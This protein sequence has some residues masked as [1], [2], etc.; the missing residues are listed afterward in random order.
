M[1][2][3]MIMQLS[4]I[5]KFAI[6]A[7][8]ILFAV[9]IHEVAHGWMASKLGD[10]T[11][12]MLGRL[13]LNPIRHIDPVGTIII[14][15]LLLWIGGFIFGWAKPVPINPKNLKNPRRDLALISISGPLSNL[16]MAVIWAM[17]MK[18]GV[19]LTQAGIG[20]AYPII[21]MGNAGITINL[22]LGLLNLIPIPPLDGGHFVSSILPRRLAHYY[23]RL[24]RY[25]FIII[26]LLIA[27][28]ALN[29]ILAPP[30]NGLYR[31]LN[32]LFRL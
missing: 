16:F 26:L 7:L 24:E 15:L 25:G 2:N 21:L 29:F 31:L 23:D 4:F 27:T 3:P 30:I 32:M 8:P 1:V 13:T 20:M 18:V 9:T 28:N 14:P 19:V 5:Q 11:A 17:I 6:Y 22:V 12:K 10:K